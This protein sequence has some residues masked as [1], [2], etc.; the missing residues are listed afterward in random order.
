MEE[1][2]KNFYEEIGR[3]FWQNDRDRNKEISDRHELLWTLIALKEEKR[4]RIWEQVNENR[5]IQEQFRN[6]IPVQKMKKKTINKRLP[7]K[8]SKESY[9][10][11]AR[12]YRREYDRV[13]SSKSHTNLANSNDFRQNTNNSSWTRKKKD[14]KRNKIKRAHKEIN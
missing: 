6:Y 7:K 2:R 9:D 14:Y 8:R 13:T 5:E 3:E 11:E 1:D 12:E 4:N 10:E